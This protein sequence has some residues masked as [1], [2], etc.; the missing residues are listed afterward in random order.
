MDYSVLPQK[1][2]ERFAF[3]DKYG[4]PMSPEYKAALQQL[5]FKEKIK[6]NMNI[7]AFFFGVI[8]FFVLGLWRKNLTV[9]GVAI[10]VSFFLMFLP[11]GFY[12]TVSS[13]INLMFALG[14]SLIA[15]YAY[16]LHAVKGSTSWNPLEGVFAPVSTTKFTKD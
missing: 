13:V 5:E 15:N 12:K 2:Q 14:Y 1:W 9:L 7:I 3:F 16:Y 11:L 8:Y 10:V 6:I 4:G